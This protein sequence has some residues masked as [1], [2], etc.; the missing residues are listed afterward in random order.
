MYKFNKQTLRFEKVGIWKPLTFMFISLFFLAAILSSFIPRTATEYVSTEEQLN[1]ITQEEFSQEGLAR[2]INRLNLRNPKIVFAQMQLESANFKSHKFRTLN[3][4]MG[5]KLPRNRPTTAIGE[6]NGFSEYLSW[7]D[8]V[9]DYGLWQASYTKN[10]NREQYLHY[11]RKHYAEDTLYVEKV[12]K[13][14]GSKK[15]QSLFKK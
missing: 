7:R 5:M 12:L 14:A 3:N 8:A 15:V 6:V 1:L 9:L 4:P 13:I 11:L 2:E 10:L